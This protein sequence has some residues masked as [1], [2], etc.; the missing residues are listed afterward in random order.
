MNVS[1]RYEN[2]EL[3]IKKKKQTK[4]NLQIKAAV[5]IPTMM[6]VLLK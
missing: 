4:Q 1:F 5:P 6:Q 3:T 2:T